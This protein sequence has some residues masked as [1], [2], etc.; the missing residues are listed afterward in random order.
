MKL[1]KKLKAVFQSVTRKGDKPVV[2][3]NRSLA[4]NKVILYALAGF[5]VMIL[6]LAIS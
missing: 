6:L 5:T 2:K 4:Q 3:L 1:F